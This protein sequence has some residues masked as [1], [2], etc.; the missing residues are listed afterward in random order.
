MAN[1]AFPQRP[2]PAFTAGT[3]RWQGSPVHGRAISE[4][5]RKELML[6]IRKSPGGA[7][8]IIMVFHV[9]ATGCGSAGGGPT[10]ATGG[11][12][13]GGAAHG[14]GR[15]AAARARRPPARPAE[16]SAGGWVQ[17]TRR[18]AEAAPASP[19]RDE[20][21]AGPVEHRPREAMVRRA[22]GRAAARPAAL[23]CQRREEAPPRQGEPGATAA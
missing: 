13:S 10:V 23:G 8:A 16:Q 11:A 18:A 22:G 9:L 4:G 20:P 5:A 14:R 15:A 1:L 12:G 17:R 21:P 2:F 7:V 3:L 19:G 6:P